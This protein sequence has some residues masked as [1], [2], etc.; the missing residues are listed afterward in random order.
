MQSFSTSYRQAPRDASKSTKA[1]AKKRWC[2]AGPPV[3]V[4]KAGD[5]RVRTFEESDQEEV[6]A[7]GDLL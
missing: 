1:V 3:G 4:G 2:L 6:A 5:C 7:F